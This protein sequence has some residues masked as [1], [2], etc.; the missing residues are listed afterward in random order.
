[1]N[2]DGLGPALIEQ[3]IEKKVIKDVAD[4]FSLKVD[5]LKELDRMGEKSAKNIIDAIAQ[6]KEKATLPRL[7]A[8]LGIPQVGEVA[9]Q[10]EAEHAKSLEYFL[11]TPPEVYS[12]ELSHIHG[13]GPKIAQAN[14]AFFSEQTNVEVI[15]KL[16][17]IGVNP[18]YV[19][20][21]IQ[22]PL[23]GKVFCITGTLSKP[24]DEI[25][26]LILAN[27]GKFAKTVGKGVH[28]LVVGEDVGISKL[29]KA[30]SYGTALIKESELLQMLRLT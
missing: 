20:T 13:V 30:K 12:I 1:M 24:R 14:V 19:E 2:I 18:T 21:K 15:K 7:I 4:L 9:A 26:E 5:D 10:K 8:A 25:K 28:Y 22:G 23:S 27:G 29:E 6:A 11:T 17:Q 3:L 16:I